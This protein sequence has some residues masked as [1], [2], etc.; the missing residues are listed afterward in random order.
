MIRSGTLERFQGSCFRGRGGSTLDLRTPA[1]TYVPYPCESTLLISPFS[2]KAVDREKSSQPT[3]YGKGLGRPVA[4]CSAGVRTDARGH[5]ECVLMNLMKTFMQLFNGEFVRGRERPP[6][7]GD[8]TL[9]KRHL[10][11]VCSVDVNYFFSSS[12]TL[13]S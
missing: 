4:S 13:P 7:P 5:L 6:A 12:P 8:S 11:T 2:D 1:A 10:S 9:E 3:A